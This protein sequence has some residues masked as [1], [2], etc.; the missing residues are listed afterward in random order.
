MEV[1]GAT[2]LIPDI[3]WD[4]GP[5]VSIESIESMAILHF[6]HVARDVE[7]AKK[8]GVVTSLTKKVGKEN[9]GWW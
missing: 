6:P 7:F 1:G 4:R 8:R 3:Y 2:S 5:S 9:F